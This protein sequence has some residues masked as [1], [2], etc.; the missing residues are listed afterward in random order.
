MTIGHSAGGHLALWAAARKNIPQPSP[1]FTANPI[2]IFGTVSLAGI[3]DL[4]N[5][6]AICGGA[7]FKLMGGTPQEFPDRYAAASLPHLLPLSIPQV[8]I[9][10]NQDILVPK[11]Y[12]EQYLTNFAEKKDRN[13]TF[14]CYDNSGHFELVLPTVPAGKAAVE[15]VKNLLK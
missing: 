8:F 11:N 3:P 12:V 1:I 2:P 9:Q 4:E 15:A 6:G 13:I 5:S 10:G 7:A 14:N